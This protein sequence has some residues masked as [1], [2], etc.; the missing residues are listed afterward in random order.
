MY[1]KNNKAIAK[2]LRIVVNFGGKKE[3]AMER[4]PRREAGASAVPAVCYVMTGVVITCVF[5]F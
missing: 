3:L 4:D 2:K 5:I 1:K